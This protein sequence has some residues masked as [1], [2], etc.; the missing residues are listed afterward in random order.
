V[1]DVDQLPSVGAGAVLTD[2]IE[3]KAVAVARLTEVHRQAASSW[4]VRAAHAVN[5]GEMPESAPAGGTGDFYFVEAD[6]PEALIGTIK[7]MMTERIPKKFGLD[8]FR[9][10]QVLTPQVKTVLGVTNLNKELQGVL[11]PGGKVEVRR[12][13][14]AFKIGDKVMQVQNN[15]TREVFNGDLGRVSDIDLDEQLL[16]VRF[17]GRDVEYDFSELDELQLAYAITVHKSQGAEYP[18]VVIPIHTLHYTMLQRT[19]LYTAITR[20]RKLVVLVGS[21]KALW[22][23]VNNMETKQRHSLLKWRLRAREPENGATKREGP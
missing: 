22:R 15:Y 8:P 14:T 3:S 21:R 2:L 6:E 18:A 19:L 1:G 10:V 13:D 23:A 4:I 16:T 7:Q 12:Y 17:E 5:R 9:D 20:G 11:N